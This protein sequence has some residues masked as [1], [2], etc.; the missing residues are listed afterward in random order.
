MDFSHFRG[1]HSQTGGPL[2]ENTDKIL[3]H[4]FRVTRVHF[5]KLTISMP[6][7]THH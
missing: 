2:I 6:I 1:N 3:L 5:L 7:R 4:S